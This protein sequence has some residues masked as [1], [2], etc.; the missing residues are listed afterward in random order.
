MS[1]LYSMGGALNTAKTGLHVTSHNISNIETEGYSRQRIVQNDNFYS[2]LGKNRANDKLQAGTGVDISTLNQIRDELLD[3]SYRNE[4]SRAQYYSVRGEAVLEIQDILGEING[5]SISNEMNTLWSAV[6]ALST[7]AGGIETR[8]L[9]LQTASAFAIKANTISQKINEYQN[10]LDFKVRESVD[11]INSITEQIV[12]YNHLIMKYEASGDNANDFRDQRNLL[13][14]ELSTYGKINVSEDAQGILNV[15][16]EGDTI[17]NGQYRQKMGLQYANDTTGKDY[18]V[19][20]WTSVDEI[21]KYKQTDKYV[22]NE[23]SIKNINL[24]SKT[25]NGI[26]KG[27]LSVR[28]TIGATA[29]TSD[30][31]VKGYVIPKIQKEL[32]EFI[33]KM[34]NMFNDIVTDG[35]YDMYGD[36]AVE[37]IFI[38][39][40]GTLDANGNYVKGYFG[41]I[42]V[43]Q[44]LIDNPMLLGLSSAQG[45][46]EDTSVVQKILTEWKN[47]E[48]KYSPKSSDL[49]YTQNFETYYSELVGRIGSIGEEASEMV[50]NQELLLS[51]IDSRRL[52]VSGVSLDEEMSNMIIYQ[53]AYGAA[54]KIYNTIDS[55]L[56]SV[57]TMV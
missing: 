34:T 25:D 38:M 22:Y 57:I 32:D 23:Q 47:K 7:S 13:L 31:D 12:H 10:K 48:G 6:N 36:E 21:L 51:D 20:V 46:V 19:P 2:N 41:N 16:F 4:S 56:E 49:G 42:K 33:T 27:I 24:D 8:S 11:K 26:L 18:V 3:K 37:N 1:S 53:Y 39:E 44:K 30:E 45:A 55:M 14:D 50:E 28:G 15:S 17:I 40:D 52:S 5:E 29:N 43:N 9:F 35:T 54:A